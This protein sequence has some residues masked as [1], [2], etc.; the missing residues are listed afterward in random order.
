MME[1]SF[2]KIVISM[3]GGGGEAGREEKSSASCNPPY[4]VYLP[5]VQ[6]LTRSW[7]DG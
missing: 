2:Y 7:Y 3:N 1:Q 5:G 6:S 4:L